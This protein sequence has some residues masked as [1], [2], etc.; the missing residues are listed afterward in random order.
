MGEGDQHRASVKY[1]LPSTSLSSST[2]SQGTSVIQGSGDITV[3]SQF[4]LT[5]TVS[6]VS[7][8]PNIFWSGP[9]GIINPDTP[10]VR[11][12]GPSTDGDDT[13]LTLVF[14]SLMPSLTGTYVCSNTATIPNTVSYDLFTGS[15]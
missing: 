13:S 10:N 6:G 14:D 12:V 15:Q 5:C 3:G 8:A 7:P 4:N 9:T 1:L 2:V 11:L